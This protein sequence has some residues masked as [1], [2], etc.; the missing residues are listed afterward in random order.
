MKHPSLYLD[1]YL[2]GRFV[3]QLKFNTP[4]TITKSDGTREF[5]IADIEKYVTDKRPSLKG[6]DFKVRFSNQRV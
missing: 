6:K 5:Y 3:C 2:Y 4:P 1:I